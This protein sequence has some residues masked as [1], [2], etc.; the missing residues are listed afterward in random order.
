MLTNQQKAAALYCNVSLGAVDVLIQQAKP[1]SAE[2]NRLRAAEV[3]LN[4]CLDTYR[5]ESFPLA[6]VEKASALI[7][8][9]NDRIKELYP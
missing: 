9:I 8:L 7:D 6:D 3:A 4:R 2:W 1:K 5:L